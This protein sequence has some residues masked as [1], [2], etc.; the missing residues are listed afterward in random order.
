MKEK[1]VFK[2]SGIAWLGKIPKH[3]EVV[4]LKYLAKKVFG[5]GTPDTSISSYWATE[6]TNSYLWVSI[7]DMTESG[8]IQNTKKYITEKGLQSS[9]A[10]IVPP[11]SILYSIYASL[12]KIAYSNKFLTTNQAIL[13]IQTR[14]Y[15]FYKFLFY[16]LYSSTKNIIALSSMTTQNNINL[17]IVQNLKIPL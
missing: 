7:E 1:C 15:L 17:S 4:R 11:F 14:E 2:E 9:S 8:F 16:Y 12:G 13:A 3:W 5:G 6:Q 10:K